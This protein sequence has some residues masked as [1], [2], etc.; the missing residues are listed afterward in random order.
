MSGKFHIQMVSELTKCWPHGIHLE[1][2][3]S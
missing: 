1:N 3:A 2:R